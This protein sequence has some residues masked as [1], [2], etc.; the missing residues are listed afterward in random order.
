MVCATHVDDLV[1]PW[2]TGDP[3]HFSIEKR[4][5]IEDGEIGGR[6]EQVVLGFLPQKQVLYGAL[7]Y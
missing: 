3:A 6:I 7:D 2:M 5:Q 1:E 4:I